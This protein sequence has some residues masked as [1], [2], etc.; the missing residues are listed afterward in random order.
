MKEIIKISITFLMTVISII[1]IWHN[2]LISGNTSILFMLVFPI[3]YFIKKTIENQD[4]R[5]FIISI[6]ISIIF[7]IIQLICSSI[8]IDY[9][10][11]NI[12]DNW[13]V[14]NFLGYTIFIWGTI[15]TFYNFLD[16]CNKKSPKN[17][18]HLNFPFIIN[19]IFIFLAWL[20]YFLRYYPGLLT[21]DSCAQVEQAIGLAQLSNHHPVIHTGIISLF[22]NT[23]KIIF[24]D[25]NIGVALFTIFQMITMAILFSCV[26]Q[27]MKKKNMSTFIR[28]LTL[29]YYMFYPINALFSVTMWKDILFA[30]VVPIYIIS[31]IDLVFDTENFLSNKK[32]I[33]KYIIFSAFVMF[34][35]NNGLYI[36]L[37]TI[38]ITI[39]SLIK[40]WKKILPISC[41]LIFSYFVIKTCIFNIF[42]IKE[43]SVREILSIPLQQI[44]RVE[45]YHKQELDNNTIDEI[46]LFF[47][48]DDIGNKYNPIISDPVKTE[49]DDE[50]FSNNKIKFIKLWLK[51][52]KPYFK[53]YV[54]SFLSNSYG[55]YYPEAKHWVA[56]RTM[57]PNNMG[58]RQEPLI[59]GEIVTKIDSLI[60]KRDIPIISM[61]FSIGTAFWTI[62]ISLGYEILNKRYKS[63]ILYSV[64]FILWLTLIASPVFCEYRYAY[65]L[66][67]TLPLFIGWNLRKGEIC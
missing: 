33:L 37:L 14:I 47:K 23:G 2:F 30:G 38:P 31:L 62:I 3:Y 63:I 67:T 50:Y 46:N 12:L 59:K 6:T 29:L 40:Y 61:F 49:L 48:C 64:I 20:P 13:L 36:V 41:M 25:I 52:L 60:E 21:A 24:N 56:N 58:I 55:Y 39:I 22:V 5:K 65:S 8:N 18:N 35:R 54:E 45:K 9:T 7:S 44:A 66:F 51:L 57:E 32:S 28:I 42:E 26:L 15:S 53:D 19:V 11:N 10:L 16:K 17:Q 27:Y 1:F 43:G 4:K 34:L